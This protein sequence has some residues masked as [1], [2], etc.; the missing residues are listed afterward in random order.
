MKPDK[1][2]RRIVTAFILIL[3]VV[4]AW[5]L[6][7]LVILD[8]VDTSNVKSFLYRS[9]LGLTLL[10]VFF[11]KALFDLIYPW[12]VDRKLPIRESTLLIVYI[13]ALTFG[14]IFMV[15]RLILLYL[16]SR[17]AGGGFIL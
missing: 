1:V 6:Y 17:Q 15:I 11:G 12:V 10:I 9:A 16:K 2:D 5:L 4:T 13:L 8:R 3:W 7:P 14:I